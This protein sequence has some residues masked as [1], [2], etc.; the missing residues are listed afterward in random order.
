MCD[1]SMKL[2]EVVLY[3]Y[4]ALKNVMDAS[5]G[6]RFLIVCDDVKREVGWVFAEAGLELGLNTRLITL[7]T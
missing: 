1:L 4:N 3:A 5:S 2:R 6:E 7:K